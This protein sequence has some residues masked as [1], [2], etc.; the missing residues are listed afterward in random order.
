MTSEIS[1]AQLYLQSERNLEKWKQSLYFVISATLVSLFYSKHVSYNKSHF[2]CNKHVFPQSLF[3]SHLL[4]L[5]LFP[6]VFTGADAAEFGKYRSCNAIY[7]IQ[8]SF[9]SD[10]ENAL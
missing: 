7:F 5:P 9:V 10:A 6:A 8:K 1:S 4:F 2:V 3:C